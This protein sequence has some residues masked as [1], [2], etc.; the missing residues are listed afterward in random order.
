MTILTFLFLLAAATTVGL[1]LL[2]FG[3]GELTLIGGM[4][5]LVLVVFSLFFSLGIP[6]RHEYQ[7]GEF[8][9]DTLKTGELVISNEKGKL[10]K[11]L[12]DTREIKSLN[13]DSITI[14][15]NKAV[16]GYNLYKTIIIKE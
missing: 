15:Q 11:I 6:A 9:L 4:F 2:N 10:R 14:E 5:L 13:K 1:Y 7:D 12:S 8:K 16:W 3:S